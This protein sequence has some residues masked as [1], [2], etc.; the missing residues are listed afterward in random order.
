MNILIERIDKL[1]FDFKRL[2]LSKP[3]SKELIKARARNIIPAIEIS[4]RA[5]FNIK[6]LDVLNFLQKRVANIIA[7]L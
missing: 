3:E 5:Q 2:D 6:Y 1:E 4:K 7:Q